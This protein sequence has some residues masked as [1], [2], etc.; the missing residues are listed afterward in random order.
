MAQ[1][2]A[3]AQPHAA[4][5]TRVTGPSTA[6]RVGRRASASRKK[7]PI[8]KTVMNVDSLVAND[9]ASSA[10]MTAGPWGRGRSRKR[11]IATIRPRVRQAT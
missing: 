10:P 9:S 3:S 6:R 2:A 8:T 5:P 4:H 1:N 7:E 11:Q